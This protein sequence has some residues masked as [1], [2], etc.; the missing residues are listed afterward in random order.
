MIKLQSGIFWFFKIR[1]FYSKLSLNH[2]SN[3]IFFF[4]SFFAGNYICKADNGVG[5]A[6]ERVITLQVGFP[7]KVEMPVPRSPQALGYEIEL[8]CNIEAFPSTTIQWLKNGT[9][10]EN[11][12]NY[13]INHFASKV[14]YVTSTLL[15]CTFKYF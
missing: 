5:K 1:E 8:K 9:T 12:A 6:K 15:V 13:H 11:G 14:D 3:L 10:I 4:P 7:P 2:Y